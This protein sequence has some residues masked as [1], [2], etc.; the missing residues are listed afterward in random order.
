MYYT[1]LESSCNEDSNATFHKSLGGTS[2]CPDFCDGRENEV[3]SIA[4]S[5]SYQ[6]SS[7]F[8]RRILN[9]LLRTCRF[10][11]VTY[12]KPENKRNKFGFVNFLYFLKKLILSSINY[13][14]HLYR[15]EL[16]LAHDFGVRQICF[17]VSA[18][19]ADLLFREIEISPV[20]QKPR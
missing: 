6:F 10:E 11:F 2:K 18:W 4:E 7:G 13:W 14:R 16:K 12:S 20:S 3:W 5:L 9:C 17:T 8:L 15:A 1:L 19:S